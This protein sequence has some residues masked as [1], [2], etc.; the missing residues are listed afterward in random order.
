MAEELYSQ[1]K[2]PMQRNSFKAR[3]LAQLLTICF[4]IC[5]ATSLHAQ[6]GKGTLK[7]TVTTAGNE[8]AGYV[9]VVLKGTR[10]AAITGEDGS[11]IMRNIPAGNYEIAVSLI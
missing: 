10:K 11:F 3:I 8:P 2:S 9:T 7:G 4:L 5:S 1:K 6:E